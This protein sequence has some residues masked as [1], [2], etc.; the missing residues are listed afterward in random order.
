MLRVANPSFP[1]HP[2][3]ADA[4][5]LTIVKLARFTA[6]TADEGIA[7]D[8]RDLLPLVCQLMAH[9][10]EDNGPESTLA[11]LL[12]VCN[13]WEPD[14]VAA[15]NKYMAKVKAK[16]CASLKWA[17][18][19]VTP[20]TLAH[21]GESPFG[22]W[23]GEERGRP[24]AAVPVKGGIALC[25][26]ETVCILQHLII[27]Q[28]NDNDNVQL[29]FHM[30]VGRLQQLFNECTSAIINIATELPSS[31]MLAADS[32]TLVILSLE[33]F[34]PTIAAQ[35]VQIIH[36]TIDPV[37]GRPGRCRGERPLKTGAHPGL[38]LG[39]TLLDCSGVVG[40]PQ[41]HSRCVKR[42]GARP[43]CNDKR[44][45]K[46]EAKVCASLKWAF[47]AATPTT[48][49]EL[50]LARA[51]SEGALTEAQSQIRELMTGESGRWV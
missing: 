19:A 13:V 14:H 44:V 3:A 42:V 32:V 11:E 12:A 21:L 10:L 17:L 31:C 43:H 49:G 5:A 15:T 27:K 26:E 20:T 2:L 22:D 9:K 45:A 1:S 30:L 16:V 47:N 33:M 34:T 40:L 41:R 8:D 46:L 48:F 23:A 18:N 6:T 36:V 4:I 39:D 7:D 38:N 24:A 37:P 25:A 35:N 28:E 50:F 51:M 29:G